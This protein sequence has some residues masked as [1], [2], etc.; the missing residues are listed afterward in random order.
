MRG[1]N[2]GGSLLFIIAVP[3]ATT[4]GGPSTNKI[5]VTVR[6]LPQNSPQ[7]NF[8]IQADMYK[9]VLSIKRSFV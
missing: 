8:Y 2:L 3:T 7:L 1:T 4:A 9:S 5:N 6:E